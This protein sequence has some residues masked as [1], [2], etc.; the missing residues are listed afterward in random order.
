MSIL[1]KNIVFNTLLSLSQML[2]PLITFPY[3]SRILGPSGIGQVSFVDSLTQYFILFSAVGIP[4]YGVR[5]L[6]KVKNSLMKSS[7]LF[8]ELVVLHL[9]MTLILLLVFIVVVS[10]LY[11]KGINVS[12]FLIGGALILSNV[13]IVEWYFQS[14]EKFDYI[15]KRTIFLRLVFIA[16][17]FVLVKRETDV[18][19]YYLLFLIL[20]L[21]NAGVN[22]YLVLQTDIKFVF[23]DLDLYKHVKPLLFLT[24]CSVVGSVYVL[25]DNV[26][27]GILSSPESVGYYSS[28]IKITKVPI[29][30][31]NAL[32]I[33]LVPKL[34]ESFSNN[35]FEA[36]KHYITS[37]VRYV[38]TFGIP[39]SVGIAITSKWSVMLI[40]GQEFLPAIELVRYMSPIVILIA[41]NCVFFYQLFTP[42]NKERTMLIILFIS[43]LISISLN[44]ILI[45]KFHHFGAAITTTITELSVLILSLHFSKKLFNLTITPSFLVYPVI[46][47]LIFFPIAYLVDQ[48][49]LN[50]GL[51]L[52]ITA[53]PC[54]AIYYFLQRFVFKD[55]IILKVEAFIMGIVK[56]S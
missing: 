22:F 18:V 10:L 26:I 47:S 45:P 11:S 31:I 9:I 16:L 7:K 30:L 20:Q 50:N 14:Q 56:R 54:I 15:T 27:L 40:S 19:K 38:L 3:V 32:G 4:L 13:F 36:V 12:L 41:L 23:K 34:S 39:L 37:S 35:D 49:H 6:S 51:K 17:M 48:F 2:F 42:G 44:L 24:A 55:T 5:E 1:K 29:S 21:M 43:S 46:S 28:A 52:T 53:V 8:S 25:L 33:V